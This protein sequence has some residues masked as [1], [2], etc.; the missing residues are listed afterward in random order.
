M[1][2]LTPVCNTQPVAG[3]GV[4]FSRLREKHEDMYKYCNSDF[5]RKV[6]EIKQK[7][8]LCFTLILVR[9]YVNGILG[10]TFSSRSTAALIGLFLF[11]M[12]KLQ[13]LSMESGVFE[14]SIDGLV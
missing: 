8:V 12:V 7:A 13:F 5:F 14:E 2:I 3:L 9:L 6:V 11:C 4:H 10:I 1:Y